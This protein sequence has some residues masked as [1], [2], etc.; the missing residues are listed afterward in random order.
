[1]LGLYH[2]RTQG[3]ALP[4]VDSLIVDGH[5]EISRRAECLR[6]PIRF[7]ERPPHRFLT[8][9]NAEEHLRGGPR[10]K[11]TKTAIPPMACQAAKNF[12]FVAPFLGQLENASALQPVTAS[13]FADKRRPP[14]FGKASHFAD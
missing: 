2:H 9:V 12:P 1:M 7:F 14:G 3:C 4:V 5:A 10:F 13:H 11:F 6:F 8:L